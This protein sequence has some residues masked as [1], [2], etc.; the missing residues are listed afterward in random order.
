[1]HNNSTLIYKCPCHVL[2]SGRCWKS[3]NVPFRWVVVPGWND[4]RDPSAK[5]PS[6]WKHHHLLQTCY[7][8]WFPARNRT[9]SAVCFCHSSSSSHYWQQWW[10]NIKCHQGPTP[11]LSTYHKCISRLT[12]TIFRFLPLVCSVFYSVCRKILKPFWSYGLM[13]YCLT[14]NCTCKV[15]HDW[16]QN[17]RRPSC[18]ENISWPMPE[19]HLQAPPSL[20]LYCTSP[21]LF[22]NLLHF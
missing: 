11:N 9:G 22:T 5:L 10:A 19:M 17:F 2:F 20:S 7:V 21:C 6:S 13:W 14:F 18:S 8:Q 3:A 12:F 15:W 1:M 16:F 4:H